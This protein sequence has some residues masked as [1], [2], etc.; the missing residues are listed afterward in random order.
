[1]SYVKQGRTVTVVYHFRTRTLLCFQ[2]LVPLR[3]LVLCSSSH[4][5][6][7]KSTNKVH[8]LT[9]K[10]IIIF[11]VQT[12]RNS[13]LSLSNLRRYSANADVTADV[14]SKIVSRRHFFADMIFSATSKVPNYQNKTG[15][16]SLYPNKYLLTTYFKEF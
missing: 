11:Y 8:L 14:K 9:W 4:L 6:F 15:D 2:A 10:E 7:I 1:M 16:K 13:V 5:I 3:C 12:V